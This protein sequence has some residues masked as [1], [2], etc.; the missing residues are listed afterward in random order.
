MTT[1]A[2]IRR[3]VCNRFG[4]GRLELLERTKAR[5]VAR[6]RQ[7]GMYLACQD[8]SRSLAMVGRHF[9]GLTSWTVLHACRN[10]ERLCAAD[11]EFAE[12]VRE[13]E[14]GIRG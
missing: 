11:P 4:L 2:E 6:P 5:R 9:G 13:L 14:E 1:M 7:V 3:H 8:D 10:V 12:V